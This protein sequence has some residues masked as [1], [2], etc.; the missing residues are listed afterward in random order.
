MRYLRLAT[1]QDEAIGPY[2]DAT[3]GVT[4]E[5][6]LTPATEIAKD[7][8]AYGAG[9]TGT[10]DAEGWYTVTFSATHTDTLGSFMLKSQDSATHL[11]VWHEF[12]VVP[13]VVYDAMILGTDNLD[14]DLIA[15]ATSAQLVDDVWDEV[16]T[17]ATHNVATSSGRRLRTL[18]DFGLYEGGAVWIDTVNGTAGTVDFENGT[19]NN[20]VDSIADALTIAGSV[21]L[22]IFH[23]LPGSSFTLAASVAGFEFIGFSYTVALGGQSI[24]GTLFEGAM[25]TGNDSGANAVRAHFVRCE[26]GT[27]TL[28][29]HTFK[30]CQLAGDIVLAEAADYFWDQCYSGVAGL[31]TP[32]VDY[33]AAV[34]TKTL[35]LRHYSGGIELKN[36]GA[37]S[38]THST[39]IEGHGQLVINANCAGGAVAVRGHFKVT[40]TGTVTLTDRVNF[41]SLLD[42]GTAVYDRATDSLQEISDALPTAI[43]NAD[44]LLDRADSI[45]TGL[46]LRGAQRLIAA[47]SAGKLSGGATTTITIRNAVA[48]SKARITATVDA[49]GN[50]SAI[51]EDVT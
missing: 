16:L 36:H 33:Q 1:I 31:S 51:T 12:M 37:G 20:P 27:N 48:D 5:V 2:L 34:E 11:P 17:G 29:E 13:A 47:A 24:S 32:A 14:V 50:R 22:V 42:D 35:S 15:T 8:A 46:T 19:V 43:E 25:I 10:H 9:P 39:S 3:D 28:G 38:G 26:M 6:G 40:E 44:A 41:E 18:Q 23:V 4:E 21:G 7:G 49:S 30:G 45:E